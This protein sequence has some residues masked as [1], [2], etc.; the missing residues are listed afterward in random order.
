MRM[1]ALKHG[2]C[3]CD[4]IAPLELPHSLH[5]FHRVSEADEHNVV[6][7]QLYDSLF[8]ILN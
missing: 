4:P 5:A 6:R 3:E 8:S 7:Y 2:S 1:K